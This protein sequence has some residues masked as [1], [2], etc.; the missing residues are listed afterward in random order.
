MEYSIPK[1]YFVNDL[2]LDDMFFLRFKEYD[3]TVVRGT[4]QASRLAVRGGSVPNLLRHLGLGNDVRAWRRT[5]DQEV[6]CSGA[7]FKIYF[8]YQLFLRCNKKYHRCFTPV[9]L[10][11]TKPI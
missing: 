8:S 2:E 10:Y 11:I 6:T 5:H 3:S 4:Q 7:K 1:Q 9:M